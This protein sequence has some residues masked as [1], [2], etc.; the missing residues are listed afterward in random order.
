[1]KRV[2]ATAAT[3]LCLFTSA[4]AE[5][6]PDVTPVYVEQ[7]RSADY[8][9]S[10]YTIS[11]HT[12]KLIR[13]SDICIGTIN[14]KYPTCGGGYRADL[15]TDECDTKNYI[16]VSRNGNYEYLCV[17][18]NFSE[19]LRGLTMLGSLNGYRVPDWVAIKLV[20]PNQ[21]LCTSDPSSAFPSKTE[22]L[23]PPDYT[24]PTQCT[25]N[26]VNF[27]TGEKYERIIDFIPPFGKM[28]PI[29]GRRY[30]SQRREA[31]FSTN[32]NTGTG[33]Y[34]PLPMP[35]P[36][37][38]GGST[39]F[40]IPP[41]VLCSSN[42]TG[43]WT[44]QPES[45]S[46]PEWNCWIPVAPGYVPLLGFGLSSPPPTSSI[47][48]TPNFLPGWD[49][50]T[51]VRLERTFVGI[52]DDPSGQPLWYAWTAV[53]PPGPWP[54][55]RSRAIFYMK[56]DGYFTNATIYN[57]FPEMELKRGFDPP[58]DD[59]ENPASG[60]PAL[61][62]TNNKINSTTVKYT[63]LFKN[64]VRLYF[65]INGA[66]LGTEDAQGNGYIQGF[67]LNSFDH[68]DGDHLRIVHTSR[69]ND[70]I[71]V[72]DAGETISIGGVT[73]KL[74][75]ITYGD[76]GIEY[77]YPSGQPINQSLAR[78]TKFFPNPMDSEETLLYHTEYEYDT[79]PGSSIPL[80]KTKKEV[81]D[82]DAGSYVESMSQWDYRWINRVPYATASEKIDYT[83]GTA[84]SQIVKIEYHD[85]DNP[86]TTPAPDE[87]LVKTKLSDD[88]GYAVTEYVVDNES[89]QILES[90]F[91]GKEGAEAD[92][93]VVSTNY[94]YQGHNLTSTIT[95]GTS[96]APGTSDTF[97]YHSATEYDGD[98]PVLTHSLRTASS[99]IDWETV[100]HPT[101]S[102]TYDGE[103][104]ALIE[105]PDGTTI[106][107]D[108][109]TTG[110]NTGQV[111]SV[112]LE[113]AVTSPTDI[114]YITYD[115]SPYN[116]S[117]VKGLV[118]TIQGP[119]PANAK[120]HFTYNTNGYV[121]T[122]SF[123]V[124][125]GG[126]TDLSD[127]EYT[128]DNYGNVT[129]VTYADPSDVDDSDG[130]TT[131]TL[132]MTSD[133]LG[134]V[135]EVLYPEMN[136][137]R[138]KTA[139]EYLSLYLVDNITGIDGRVSQFEYT[140]AMQLSNAE[141]LGRDGSTVESSSQR[142]YDESGVLK[143]LTGPD[144]NV[145][146]RN[147]AQ[148]SC[149]CMRANQ[150]LDEHGNHYYYDPNGAVRRITRRVAWD[151][152]ATVGAGI[153]A[154]GTLTNSTVDSIV[155]YDYD[156]WG[157]IESLDVRN[158]PS[159]T[160]HAGGD[161]EIAYSYDSYTSPN[162]LAP[163]FP[164]DA[165]YLIGTFAR[166]IAQ[167]DY[168]DDGQ[169]V[170]GTETSRLTMA[171]DNFSRPTTARTEYGFLSGD[172]TADITIAYHANS[173]TVTDVNTPVGD[174]SFTYDSQGLG[175]VTS[176]DVDLSDLG[177]SAPDDIAVD[178]NYLAGSGRVDQMDITQGAGSSGISTF[179]EVD[180]LGRATAV[181]Y[182]NRDGDP[183]LRLEYEY[184]GMDWSSAI[185][186][187]GEY[188]Y[189]ISEMR[190]YRATT[191]PLVEPGSSTITPTVSGVQK[192]FA[193]FRQRLFTYDS[194]GR[195]A[196]EIRKDGT[197]TELREWDF[198]LD[199]VNNLESVS[200]DD[201]S[202]TITM[203]TATGTHN[204]LTTAT[205]AGA[206][207][208][209]SLPVEGTFDVDEDVNI[210]SARVTV[211]DGAN[212]LWQDDATV[213]CCA[214][215][216]TDYR[217]TGSYAVVAQFTPPTSNTTFEIVV[218]TEAKR[219]SQDPSGYET[220]ETTYVDYMADSDT[221]YFY[222]DRLNLIKKVVGDY[223][224][225][226]YLEWDYEYDALN[227]MTAA[228][229]PS[230]ER[231]EWTYDAQTRRL[232]GS[233]GNHIY[234]PGWET[235]ADTDDSLSPN[236]VYILGGGMDGQLGFV[237]KEGTE[238][239]T[240]YYLR[241]HLGSVLALVDE[242]GAIV[243]SY[244]YEPYGLPTF[245]DSTGTLIA[246]SFVGNRM[247]YTGREWD[248]DLEMYHYRY[249]TYD[250]RSKRFMQGDPIGLNGGWN[251]YAYVGGNPVNYIDPMG[252]SK[253]GDFFHDYLPPIIGVPI[254]GIIDGDP[255]FI[256]GIP[257]DI[258]DQWVKAPTGDFLVP[259]SIHDEIDMANPRY[260]GDPNNGMHSW[261]C[262]TNAALASNH[263]PFSAPFIWIGGVAHE[264]IDLGSMEGEC[265][266][267]G[268]LPWIVDST[269]DV[270]ANT[271]G[272]GI[273]LLVPPALG[274]AKVGAGVGIIILGPH[275]PDANGDRIPDILQ[276]P[277]DINGDGIP[278]A[279]ERHDLIYQRPK[280]LPIRLY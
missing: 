108:V 100:E 231:K 110:E 124:P 248:A 36:M 182:L 94:G 27:V 60:L 19:Q 202:T 167:T 273:G 29:F 99:T 261:H 188:P 220:V 118:T 195:L 123:E 221:L 213:D 236:I 244:E 103:Y 2:L 61:N 242:T 145:Y 92:P 85:Y 71:N 22:G 63:L 54:T 138:L 78:V 76:F 224:S 257:K 30:G 47:N 171:Y 89:Y 249:R 214:A 263:G 157:H 245:Y 225:G 159:D 247:L 179:S 235:I 90:H 190:E 227:R 156:D 252:L 121:E 185:H 116:A 204:Q 264:T 241:D 9:G 164:G 144:S 206:L 125:G 31:D 237:K 43:V 258:N 143:T 137:H 194:L 37:S 10:N 46:H 259:Q 218:T 1:M 193:L 86:T 246:D 163:Y 215:T 232:G 238:W 115:E 155:M 174:Y 152:S 212:V 101:V 67:G 17:L 209:L 184:G 59:Q 162:S 77:A 14:P 200:L 243:E 73:H 191:D 8:N 52:E 271:A 84:V 178:Y 203:G 230:N 278:D 55:T 151:W 106:N 254:K 154:D 28:S 233:D 222:D 136:S 148:S 38:P 126:M 165:N 251:Y 217:E 201:H 192:T 223:P 205:L 96:E 260:K 48:D 11:L 25:G 274:P 20:D 140:E 122:I 74:R 83:N 91:L 117:N 198:Q 186:L 95:T 4:W 62:T 97:Y 88:E 139:T 13:V 270:V 175:R 239:S 255:G 226:T 208:T 146:R 216:G 180:A 72:Y 105:L 81:A 58:K 102:F 177:G 229:L 173:S 69:P 256:I 120:A 187:D 50:S 112:W 147:F 197:G 75:T 250:P 149:G 23:A 33:R 189:F 228:E 79:F 6:C 133:P 109:T 160:T 135:W 41:N 15:S 262:A 87:R 66:F 39:N 253:L 161:V 82:N 169:T 207:P 129:S 240:Y 7:L 153:S 93:P 176:V 119:A 70:P 128:Y 142:E 210:V 12:L 183:L 275:D 277:W 3:I 21:D 64:G 42:D 168:T 40:L 32:F 111:N 24:C 34:K 134:R 56:D 150:D 276:K 44:R 280:K 196:N 219:D 234:G 5:D 170:T 107:F 26:P 16:T 158:T 211:K 53:L 166:G 199:I 65:D 51:D 127:I 80:L 172:P 98:K 35:Y 265:R 57:S 114:T 113:D 267:Q 279:I 68:T 181:T 132:N 130:I 49:F 272:L 104:L 18:G 266:M 45:T 131:L 268:I 269:G 141:F